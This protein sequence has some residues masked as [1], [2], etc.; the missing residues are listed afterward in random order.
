MGGAMSWRESLLHILAGAIVMGYAIAGLFFLRFWRE[1]RDRLFLAFA[2]AFW[3]LG[4]Q[5]MALVT[6]PEPAAD[7]VTG[8]YMI[9][10]AA[11]VLILLAILDKNRA[12]RRPDG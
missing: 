12:H 11:F 1:T 7:T 6:V 2:V 3:I 10:L 5:R 4:L 8:F 9:R